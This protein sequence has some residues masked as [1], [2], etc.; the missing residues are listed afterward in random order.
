[1]DMATIANCGACSLLLTHWSPPLVDWSRFSALQTICFKA[2]V[3]KAG[4]IGVYC[5]IGQEAAG[6]YERGL[7]V[8][9]HGMRGRRARWSAPWRSAAVEPRLR[10]SHSPRFHS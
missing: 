7:Q 10:A 3:S 6:K 2:A 4:R 9:Q 1:M 8:G 5:S